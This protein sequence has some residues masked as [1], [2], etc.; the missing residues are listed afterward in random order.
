MI[1]GGCGS[2]AKLAKMLS[3]K[4]AAVQKT[5]YFNILDDFMEKEHFYQN[6]PEANTGLQGMFLR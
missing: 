2:W 5:R 4:Q 1:V 3:G 6:V